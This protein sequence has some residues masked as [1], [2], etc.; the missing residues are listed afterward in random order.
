MGFDATDAK[1]H[2]KSKKRKVASVDLTIAEDT[3]APQK[4][5]V[6]KKKTSKQIR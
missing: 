2:K 6:K 4:V 3:K 1:K 5:P